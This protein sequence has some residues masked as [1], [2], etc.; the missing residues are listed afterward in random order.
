MVYSY[1]GIPKDDNWLLNT[2]H[3]NKPW[4]DYQ[5]V[6]MTLY[7]LPRHQESNRGLDSSERTSQSLAVAP[8]SEGHWQ[9]PQRVTLQQERSCA[10]TAWAPQHLGRSKSEGN[11]ITYEDGQSFCQIPKFDLIL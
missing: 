11:E 5:W 9:G 6:T 2:P 7:T 10:G 4:V 8:F 1:G 3:I